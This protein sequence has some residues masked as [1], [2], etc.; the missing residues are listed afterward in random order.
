MIDISTKTYEDMCQQWARVITEPVSSE[1]HIWPPL[2]NE[3]AYVRKFLSDA[4][5]QEKLFHGEKVQLGFVDAYEIEHFYMDDFEE[6]FFESLGLKSTEHASIDSYLSSLQDTKVCVFL[7]GLD[8]AMHYKNIAVLKQI[9]SLLD[10]HPHFS[11]ILLTELNIPESELYED[12]ITRELL[13][14]SVRYQ[15]LL[16]KEDTD[17]FV[18]TIAKRWQLTLTP[19]QE[20]M[21]FEEIGG[22]PLLLREALRIIRDYPGA[23][24]KDV[25]EFPWLVRKGFAIFKMLSREDQSTIRGLLRGEHPVNISQYLLQTHLVEDN[26]I[27]ILYWHEIRNT[28]FGFD[29][30]HVDPETQYDFHFTSL[31]QRVFKEL[32]KKQGV[33]TRDE[34]AQ[35][36]WHDAWE[37]RY[38]DW[39]IDQMIHRLREKL[40]NV[41]APYI[42]ETKK[43]EGFFLM[44]K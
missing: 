27:G 38:S 28:I 15:P 17:I 18:H 5:L 11:L 7:V 20:T 39:A 30:L 10:K 6:Q 40:E 2:S 13:I 25:L 19:E 21:F 42:L 34:I 43:G 37:D 23:S 35:A 26:K 4:A 29:T 16:A 36:I 44:H 33:V 31:E 8:T 1:V 24:V 22:H 41:K 14:D 12:I 3:Y 9:G 32:L